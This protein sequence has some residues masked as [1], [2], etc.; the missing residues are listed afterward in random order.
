MPPL[1]DLRSDTVTKPCATMR[2]AMATARVGDDVYGEDPTVNRLQREAAKLAGQPAGL[3]MPSGT[4][5]N[6]V[7]LLSHCRRG[8]EYLVANH[9][10]TFFYEGGGAAALGGIHP[11]PIAPDADG[12]LPIEDLRRAL[13]PT[14]VHF[15]V[16]R[17]LS[18][19]NTYHG[20]VLPLD[21]LSAA[22]AFAREN[23][24]KIHLDGARAFNA[25]AAL[26][27]PLERIT[28]NFDSVSL[29]LS[30]GLGAPAGTMLVGSRAFIR[31]ARRWR[32]VTGGGMRQAG[33]L[34]AAGLH[35]LEH[36]HALAR[37]HRMA[38][39][40]A[41]RLSALPDV[42]LV[43][44]GARTNMLFFKLRRGTAQGLA[45]Y[46]RRAGVLTGDKDPVR[47]VTH[48]DLPEETPERVAEV[49]GDY[50]AMNR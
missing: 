33:I 4:Q 15:P 12:C 34:A 46:A 30:K 47:L 39:Q 29:C 25:A 50:C 23:G 41:E 35:A 49:I 36:R 42:S 27:V 5:S 43:L 45:A 16:T 11:R 28:G 1:L 8:D 10:H 31:E 17:L 3:F 6:L 9:A 14:D 22:Q 32:K 18:L 13:R 2:Q 7:A 40:L 37:D 19:E 20:R 24:L 26:D 38:Q 48:R 44:G 21:Y